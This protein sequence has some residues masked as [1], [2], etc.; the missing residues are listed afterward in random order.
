MEGREV[1]AA[2][3]GGAITPDAG[4]LPLGATEPA[5]RMVDRLG[6]RASLAGDPR[7][8][9]SIRWRRWRQR[10]LAIAGPAA[11]DL[12]AMMNCAAIHRW[13]C[14][15]ESSPGA[16][17]DCAAAPGKPRRTGWNR[18]SRN[19]R[20]TTRSATMRRRQTGCSPI[21]FLRPAVR[22]PA[23]SPSASMPPVIR[24]MVSRKR[25]FFHGCYKRYR[26]LPLYF[27]VAHFLCAKLRRS[28]IGASAGPV[29]E[30][31]RIVAQLRERWPEVRIRRGRIGVHARRTDDAVRT[32]RRRVIRSDRP[33]TTG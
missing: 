2:F 17:P 23:R 11:E 33:R 29:E 19:H 24:C 26:C 16:A 6:H 27:F 3:D 28:S 30:L 25:R 22:R 14:C 20:A 7:R 32:K 12:T 31:A 9:S 8:G 1:V 21:C 15:A 10:Y 5:I 13:R 4:A 18:R